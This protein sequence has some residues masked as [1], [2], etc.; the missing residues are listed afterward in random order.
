M[1]RR[2]GK[3]PC[4]VCQT[5]VGSNAI[6]CVGC[7][8]WVHMKYSGIKGPLRPEFRCARCLGTARAIDEREDAEVEVGNDKQ[9]SALDMLSAEGGCELAAITRCNRVWGKLRQLLP[10]LINHPLTRGKVY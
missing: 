6:F 1:L 2:S 7:K 8:R 9:S 5:G 4:G 3:E 10:L